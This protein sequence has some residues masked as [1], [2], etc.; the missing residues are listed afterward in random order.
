MDAFCLSPQCCILDFLRENI[1]SP[2]R[3]TEVNYLVIVLV[4]FEPNTFTRTDG[5]I[6][7]EPPT[8]RTI[9]K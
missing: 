7:T 8:T 2:L 1:L 3:V 5:P 6:I 4:R 9:V